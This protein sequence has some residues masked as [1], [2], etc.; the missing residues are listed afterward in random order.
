MGSSM[1]S[2]IRSLSVLSLL[3]IITIMWGGS[4]LSMGTS[5]NQIQ[6]ATTASF[7][8]SGNAHINCTLHDSSEVDVEVKTTA[9][10]INSF[11]YHSSYPHTVW[12]GWGASSKSPKRI[13]TSIDVKVGGKLVW[14]S[15]SA[16]SD[17]AD[18]DSLGIQTSPSGFNIIITGGDAGIAYR[19]ELYFVRSSLTHRKVVLSELPDTVREETDYTYTIAY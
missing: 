15:L 1:K 5:M 9:Y 11:P 3:Y 19:A 18:P 12:S 10:T 6:H 8:T 2:I 16:F 4:L 7:S 13:I 14:I 17:L